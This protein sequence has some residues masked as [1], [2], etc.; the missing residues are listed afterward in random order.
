MAVTGVKEKAQALLALV[1]KLV[2]VPGMT[3]VEASNVVNCPGGPYVRLF[4]TKAEREA[5]RKSK[6]S[7]RID[8]LILSLPTPPL[9]P[10]PKEEY[11][12]TRIVEIIDLTAPRAKRRKRL[13]GPRSSVRNG[14]TP[15]VASPGKRRVVKS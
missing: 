5:F 3:W 6:E 4:R 10:A 11:D 7:R 1:E 12:P 14:A 8:K 9:R 2:D 15:R 13:A